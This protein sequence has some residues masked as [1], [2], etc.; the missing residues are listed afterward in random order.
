METE[1]LLLGLIRESRGL[2]AQALARWVSMESLRQEIE[3][4]AVVLE[5]IPTSVE[6]PFS[7]EVKRVLHFAAEEA[8][9]LK[10]SYIGA[11]HLL[12]GLLREEGSVAASVLA[13]K[14][15]R[16]DDVRKT[17]ADFSRAPDP[18]F[19][20]RVDLRR[21]IDDIKQSV[22]QLAQMPAGSDDAAALL[23]HI[24]ASLEALKHHL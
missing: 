17:I 12:L 9:R 3:A 11:E 16:L 4:R 23:F 20:V 24:D 5:A 18:S 2:T 6:I 1:H 10:H 14:G 8:D 13:G 7:A 21:K 15:V 22:H 19:D